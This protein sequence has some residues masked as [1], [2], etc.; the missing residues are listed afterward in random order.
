MQTSLWVV[1]Y[2]CGGYTCKFKSPELYTNC[3]STRAL[4][5]FVLFVFGNILAVIGLQRAHSSN[6]H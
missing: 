5:L 4:C 6:P 1:T 2:G 3:L